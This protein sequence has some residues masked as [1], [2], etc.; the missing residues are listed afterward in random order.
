[1]LR[2]MKAKQITPILN[3]SDMA[4][5]FAWFAKWDWRK[6]W[7][8]GTPPTCDAS[9]AL[10]VLSRRPCGAGQK[11]VLRASDKLKRTPYKRKCQ[12]CG[13][14]EFMCCTSV[15]SPSVLETM[16]VIPAAEAN[17]FPNSYMVS[18]IMGT[19]GKL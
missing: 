17:D 16:A 3:V 6:L 7:D 14:H 5:S 12:C 10:K 11:C 9:P 4:A 15:L 18:R 13:K 19:P 2:A 1:M 8:W